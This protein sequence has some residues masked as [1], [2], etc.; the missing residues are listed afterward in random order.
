MGKMRRGRELARCL[1]LKW[2]GWLTRE[3]S[4][5][6]P[7]AN[8]PFDHKPVLKEGSRLHVLEFAFAESER[9]ASPAPSWHFSDWEN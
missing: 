7:R 5:L 6:L 8:K 3:Q 2:R 4:R 9:S 1:Q